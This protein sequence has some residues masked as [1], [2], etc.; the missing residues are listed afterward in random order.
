MIEERDTCDLYQQRMQRS[1][2]WHAQDGR[3]PKTSCFGQHNRNLALKC[4]STMTMLG[5]RP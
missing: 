3:F 1:R 2:E 5:L 4:T